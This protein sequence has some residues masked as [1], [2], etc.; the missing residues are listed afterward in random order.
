MFHGIKS[1][2]SA[3]QSKTKLWSVLEIASVRKDRNPGRMMLR[4]KHEG[5]CWKF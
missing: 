3:S 5:C 4:I 1:S 2:L